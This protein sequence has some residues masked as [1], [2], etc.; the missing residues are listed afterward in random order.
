MSIF[1]NVSK[2]LVLACICAASTFSLGCA[3]EEAAAPPVAPAETDG[4]AGS[5]TGS[6]TEVPPAPEEGT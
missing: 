6:G 2:A 5:T 1:G 4:G 3:Q